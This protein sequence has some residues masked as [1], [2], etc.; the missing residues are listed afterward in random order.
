MRAPPRPRAQFRVRELAFPSWCSG[1]WDVT[2][3][4][5]SVSA[6][7]GYKL[8]D[9]Y[10]AAKAEIG[11]KIF[12]RARFLQQNESTIPDRAYNVSSIGEAAFGA[13]SVL[14]CDTSGKAAQRVD[15]AIRP[16]ASDIVYIVSSQTLARHSA[17]MAP[18]DPTR[19]AELDVRNAQEVVF[20]F[21]ETVRQTVMP[22]TPDLRAR[23]S[24]KDVETTTV[25]FPV[26][27]HRFFTLQRT[28][29][30]LTREDLRYVDAKNRP[31]DV[32]WY[33]VQYT[34]T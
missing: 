32:R 31:V 14:D 9:T 12:Y 30:Y 24:V 29:T 5:Q 27:D 10:D 7:A 8:F 1:N 13:M 3:T 25:F 15:I 26:D 34:R 11:T 23:R 17:Y 6:P 33:N 28:A 19:I 16:Y 20:Y 2:S 18:P 4:L 22:D 21:S